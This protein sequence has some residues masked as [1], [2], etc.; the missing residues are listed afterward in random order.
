MAFDMYLG[1]RHEAIHDQDEYIFALASNT[2]SAYPQLLALQ[3]RFYS[4]FD[5]P[6]IQANKLLHEVLALIDTQTG[7]TNKSL[8]ALVLR[9]AIF[10]SAAAQGELAVRC[11]GD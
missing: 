2:P 3:S 11:S 9:L 10:F 7:T 4:Q 5:L 1:H 8:S 6:P